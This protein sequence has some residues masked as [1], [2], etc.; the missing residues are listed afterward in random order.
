MK[1]NIIDQ[2]SQLATTVL[3]KHTDHTI[4]TQTYEDPI[5]EFARLFI[6]TP[7]CYLL[8]WKQS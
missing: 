6:T 8:K 1:S 2:I 4:S 7:T 5:T 3:T